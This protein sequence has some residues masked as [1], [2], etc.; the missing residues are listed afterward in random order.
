VCSCQNGTGK[1]IHGF[2]AVDF[3]RNGDVLGMDDVVKLLL[4]AS[5]RFAPIE[6]PIMPP[7]KSSQRLC[8]ALGLNQQRITKR[9][10]F[11]V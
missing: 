5:E 2:I 9:K 6:K 1:S 8:K 10:R 7:D 11:M 3:K 4:R